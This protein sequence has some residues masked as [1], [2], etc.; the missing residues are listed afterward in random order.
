MRKK[1]LVFVFAAALLVAMAVPM[2]AGA[3][4]ADALPQDTAISTLE[5]RT[6]AVPTGQGLPLALDTVT[7]AGP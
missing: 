5:W 7:N 2:F 3:G 4:T 6:D 1:I